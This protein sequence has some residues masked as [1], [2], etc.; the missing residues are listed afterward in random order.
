M[1]TRISPNSPRTTRL[2][3]EEQ[4]PTK[5]KPQEPAERPEATAQ[6]T[7]AK[8]TADSAKTARERVRLDPAKNHREQQIRGKLQPS[9]QGVQSYLQNSRED[10]RADHHLAPQSVKHTTD[11]QLS[12]LQ[13]RLSSGEINPKL[14]LD[15]AKVWNSHA[16]EASTKAHQEIEARNQEIEDSNPLKNGFDPGQMIRG[17]FIRAKEGAEGMGNLV[18]QS[19]K[20]T[21]DMARAAGNLNPLS[22][23]GQVLND[24]LSETWRTGDPGGSL[25]KSLDKAQKDYAEN[26]NNVEHA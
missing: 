6:T 19:G 25:S 1:S 22:Y 17:S 7:E 24:T 21:V 10:L 9:S 11:A 14:A 23:S 3:Q 20:A 18:L 26:A 5:P 8:P 16:Q 13:T 2:H 15:Q 12:K 4:A